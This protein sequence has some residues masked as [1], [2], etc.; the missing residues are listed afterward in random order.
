MILDLFGGPGGWEEALRLLGNTEPVIAI[1]WDAWTCRT[2]SAA[3][4][5]TIRADVSKYPTKPFKGRV[6]GLIASPPCPTFSAA[7][8][9]SGTAEL[10]QLVKAAYVLGNFGWR[11]PWKLCPWVDPRT[12]LVL[13]P[14]RWVADLQP[15]W[16]AC[17]QVRAV[18]PLWET[19]GRIWR[20]MGYSVWSGVL[21]A[22]CFGVPQTRDRAILMAKRDGVCHPPEPSH[23]KYKPGE[24]QWEGP[25]GD[26]FGTRLPWV[27]MADALGWGA[28]ARPCVTV[29]AGGTQNGGAEPIAH[30]TRFREDRG[31]G[32]GATALRRIRGSGMTDRHGER[33]DRAIT[34]PAH[35]LTSKGR[36]DVWVVDRRTNSKAAGGA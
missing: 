34:E 28:D 22:E 18:A 1:E 10:P 32:L 17:E 8:S 16:I 11:D 14:L 29:T 12:P 13:E 4:H 36:S 25:R 6:T 3:G 35:T 20:E 23:Q 5:L 21:D 30:M 33:P 27:S 19:F 26:L 2:R 31:G 7:G 15:E 24:A 9:G